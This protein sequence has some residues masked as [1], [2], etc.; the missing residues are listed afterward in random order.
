MKYQYSIDMYQRKIEIV[1]G[2]YYREVKDDER[3]ELLIQ[4]VVDLHIKLQNLKYEMN[5]FRTQ[6]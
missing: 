2:Y 4:M 6:S 3:V 1:D 5:D